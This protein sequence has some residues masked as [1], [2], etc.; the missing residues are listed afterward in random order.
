[1]APDI[2]LHGMVAVNVEEHE[3]LVGMVESGPL[4]PAISEMETRAVLVEVLKLHSPVLDM[5]DGA[6]DEACRQCGDYHNSV[7]S[8]P[9][10][11][12]TVQAIMRG[13]GIEP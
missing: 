8:V 12:P 7:L 5:G 1:M 6:G 2:A 9:H 11:C 10:P 3:A 4:A 13:M